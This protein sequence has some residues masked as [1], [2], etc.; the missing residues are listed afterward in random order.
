MIKKEI[1]LEK[2]EKDIER[3][4]PQEQ[5]KLVEKIAYLLRKTYVPNK[6]ELNWSKLFGL[7]KNLWQGEDAQLYVNRLREERK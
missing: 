3:L 2:V 4:T 6:K 5:L 7:G 1:A